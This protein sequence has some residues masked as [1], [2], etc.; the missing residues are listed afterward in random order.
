MATAIPDLVDEENLMRVSGATPVHELSQSIYR[1]IFHENQV[2]R[3]RAVGAG[4]VSQ[5]CKAIAVARGQVAT[6]GRDLAT[7]IGFDTVKGDSGK[8]ISALTFHLFLR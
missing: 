4:A 6:R 2:P 1:A 7:T 8:D 5:A 3:I